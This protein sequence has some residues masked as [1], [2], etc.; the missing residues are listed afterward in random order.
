MKKFIYFISLVLL[1]ANTMA[2]VNGDANWTLLFGDD[3]TVDGRTWNPNTFIS[4]DHVWRSYPGSGVTH[5]ESELQVYQFAQCQFDDDANVIRLVSEYDAQGRI[6][7]NDYYLPSWMHEY[8]DPDGLYFFSGEIDCIKNPD[9]PTNGKYGFGYFEIRCKLP[10]HNGSFPAFWLFGNGPSTYEEIDIF[11]Y[12]KRDSE[13]DP[14]RGYSSGI[15]YNPVSTNYNL[16][17]LNPELG[18]AEKFVE[19]HHHILP[20]APDLSS[21]HTFGC[22]WMPDVV[23]WYR[24]GQV[25]AESHDVAH[26]PQSP[27]TLK[28]NYALN[29]YALDNNHEP[30]GWSGT[31]TMEVD[32][33]RVYKLRTDCD[34]DELI[35][36]SAQLAGFDHRMK[37]SITIGSA[38]NAIQAPA[39]ANTVMRAEEHITIDGEFEIPQ[40]ATMTFV[41]HACPD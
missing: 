33:V 41:T 2:Q 32:Y 18:Q 34:T 9:D 27:K 40:G 22:E 38:G 28:V 16:D 4:S 11:E 21:Y 7:E 31:D 6:A 17:T 3:F 20:S 24:D 15:W 25:V 12:S 29:K 30:D 13:G 39:G 23:R 36:T 14:Y 35:T 5:G 1:S 8:P 19:H 10:I 37:H 26:I